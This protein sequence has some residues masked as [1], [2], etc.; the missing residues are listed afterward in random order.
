MILRL[1]VKLMKGMNDIA[2][3]SILIL[4][5]LVPPHL[6]LSAISIALVAATWISP[7]A[8]K[9]ESWQHGYR[10]KSPAGALG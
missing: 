7:P 2:L 10:F 9:I 3:V 1:I 5:G 4:L 6:N 8:I